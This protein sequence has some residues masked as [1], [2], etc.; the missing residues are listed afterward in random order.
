MSTAVVD[1]LR[2]AVP[3]ALSFSTI[4]A[5]YAVSAKLVE[6]AESR[7]TFEAAFNPAVG[8]AL[9]LAL[10]AATRGWLSPWMSALAVMA[11]EL[12]AVVGSAYASRVF[13]L[14]GGHAVAVAV[15][16]Y[17]ILSIR[18]RT[19]HPPTPLRILLLLI[20]PALI[21]ASLGSATAV[22][23]QTLTSGH[24]EIW[25]FAWRWWSSDALGL[26]MGAMVIL[27]LNA[28]VWRPHGKL[29]FGE[30]PLISFAF[31]GAAALVLGP[32][33]FTA[34]FPAVFVCV[35][36]AL[37]L[38]LGPTVTSVVVLAS[39]VSIASGTGEPPFAGSYALAWSR[40]FIA[41][42]MLTCTG[43]SLLAADRSLSAAKALEEQQRLEWAMSHDELSGL[44]TRPYLEQFTSAAISARPVGQDWLA[45]I[46]IDLDDFANINV[47]WGRMI[48]DHAIVQIA[49]RLE[50]NI[51]K[52]ACVARIGGDE[53][54]V[55]LTGMA[56]EGD[57]LTIAEQLREL[58]SVPVVAEDRNFVVT[59][60]VGV[61]VTNDGDADQLLRDAEASLHDAKAR[62]RNRLAVRTLRDRQAARREQK[63]IDRFPEALAE[64][65]FD[66]AYQPILSMSG[67]TDGVEA[68]ARWFH[69]ELGLL[70]P[71]EFLPALHRSGLSSTLSD[72]L[73]D[74]AIRQVH[75]WAANDLDSAPVWLSLNVS[76]DDLLDLRLPRRLRRVLEA[77][78]VLPQHIMLEIT[79]QT[80][81]TFSADVHSQLQELRS[82]GVRIAVDDFG[83][84]FSG[85]AYLPRLAIDVVKIDRQFIIASADSRARTLL[86][87]VCSLARDLN[88]MTIIEGVETDSDLN[89]AREAGADAVQGWHLSRPAPAESVLNAM[90]KA[91]KACVP[92][93]GEG[94]I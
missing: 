46:S 31:V 9:V 71:D 16:L 73:F 52:A 82:M 90:V 76:A 61:A 81:V 69:P 15:A 48:A 50:A 92:I 75:R 87:N 78:G 33:T 4:A 65:E 62:G 67:D 26:L 84:G 64:G 1:R 14:A 22:L 32:Q 43:V 42:L 94:G 51:P 85:L 18:S 79:E 13:A 38:G 28:A 44:F 60:S 47:R 56:R 21:A 68:L 7:L 25:G 74:V 36:I 40:V 49:Q 35:W 93:G 41:L 34:T 86:R 3:G 23:V 2:A 5:S 17:F 66:C 80:M 88:L 59:A 45:L 10:L 12:L 11:G 70:M 91:R 8:V 39:V 72:Y 77:S 6:V 29:M 19:A 58:V 57:A 63:L 24:G 27:T 83:T 54:G 89:L 30:V 20:G 55:L 37:R 53:F